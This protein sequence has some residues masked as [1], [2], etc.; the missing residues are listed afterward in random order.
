MEAEFGQLQSLVHNTREEVRQQQDVVEQK[1]RDIATQKEFLQQTVDR[2]QRE[3]LVAL[4][5]EIEG[6]E[7]MRLALQKA[8]MHRQVAV[9]AAELL[10]A[11][12]LAEVQTAT[13]ETGRLEGIVGRLERELAEAVVP[14]VVTEAEQQAVAEAVEEM[15]C[16]LELLDRV[17]HRQTHLYLSGAATTTT[18]NPTATPELVEL[19]YSRPLANPVVSVRTVRTKRLYSI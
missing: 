16:S 10:A 12:R 9:E 1:D 11:E 2:M 7:R 14:I 4:E 18:P 13:L 19:D 15:I 8:I 5:M 6:R 17:S 3:K